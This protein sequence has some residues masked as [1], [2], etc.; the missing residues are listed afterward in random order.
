MLYPPFAEG[1]LDIPLS[2]SENIPK[3]KAYPK[4]YQLSEGDKFNFGLSM[5]IFYPYV[6]WSLRMA[7]MN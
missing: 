2:I 3:L 6:K 7:L 4:K 5:N 1:F